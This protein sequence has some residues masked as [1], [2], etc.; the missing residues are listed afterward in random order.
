MVTQGQVITQRQT[1]ATNR[2]SI[3]RTRAEQVLNNGHA[4]MK[5]E[6]VSNKGVKIL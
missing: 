6:R 2:S 1:L 4:M 3:T 5:L